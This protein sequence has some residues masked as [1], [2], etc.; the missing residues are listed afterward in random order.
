MDLGKYD[1]VLVGKESFCQLFVSKSLGHLKC[2]TINSTTKEFVTEE[3][4]PKL[5]NE[6][7]AS[8]RN[9]LGFLS[10]PNWS[11]SCNAETIAKFGE[12]LKNEGLVFDKYFSLSTDQASLVDNKLSTYKF[13]M[14]RDKLRKYVPHY[15]TND[16]MN[17]N[18]GQFP[19]VVRKFSESGG[20]GSQLILNKNELDK[21]RGERGFF[22]EFIR[23]F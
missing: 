3:N 9:Y 22:T 16:S 4:W 6:L 2:K 7:R 10:F 23:C 1:L 19:L 15:T 13:L 18:A 17:D 11:P 12:Y 8:G 5:L 14:T 21:V 20:R